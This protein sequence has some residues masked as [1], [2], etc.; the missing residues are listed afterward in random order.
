FFSSDIISLDALQQSHGALFAPYFSMTESSLLPHR[1]SLIS[2][3]LL[4][5]VAAPL[6]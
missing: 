4:R 2:G 3:G 5:F 6:T 1:G